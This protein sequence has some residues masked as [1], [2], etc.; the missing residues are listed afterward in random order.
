MIGFVHDM[1]EHQKTSFALLLLLLSEV[2]KVRRNLFSKE[3]LP[4]GK[5]FLPKM[6][7]SRSVSILEDLKHKR[8]GSKE[9][10]KGKRIMDRI[11]R[12]L[13]KLS[14]GINLCQILFHE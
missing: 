14:V 12:G 13:N 6:P 10:I 2:I 9:D 3:A 7:R 5:G 11:L 8:H 4:L 1:L